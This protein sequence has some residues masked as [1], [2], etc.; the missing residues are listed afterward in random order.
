[1]GTSRNLQARE[2]KFEVTSENILKWPS[3][4]TAKNH[5]KL[6]LPT[7]VVENIEM[8]CLK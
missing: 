1:M 3:S 2:S 4:E 5:L 6:N 7:L 8:I